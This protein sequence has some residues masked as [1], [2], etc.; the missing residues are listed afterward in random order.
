M[1]RGCGH[2]CK[3]CYAPGLFYQSRE[4]FLNPSP[5][6]RVLEQI[7]K[8]A[9]NYSGKEIHLCFTC[10]PYQPINDRYLLTRKT[11]SILHRNNIKVQ[12]LTK[13]GER[14]EKDFDLLA[15]KPGLSA[16]GATLTFIADDDSKESKV[17]KDL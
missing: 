11:I 4:Q 12:I 15:L 14:S 1:Y 10:D 7:Q 9:Q 2:G 17:R 8:E 6:S 16:Y 5:R 3:Y 13:G